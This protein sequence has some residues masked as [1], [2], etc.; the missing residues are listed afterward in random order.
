MTNSIEMRL[1]RVLR[2]SFMPEFSEKA[3]QFAAEP[4]LLNAHSLMAMRRANPIRP[5]VGWL[6]LCNFRETLAGAQWARLDRAS[7]PIPS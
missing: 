5:N 2:A 3:E 6:S 7:P 1:V 4:L